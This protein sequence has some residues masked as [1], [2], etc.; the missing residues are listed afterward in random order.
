MTWRMVMGW[1]GKAGLTTGKPT[2][3]FTGGFQADSF[4]FQQL[5]QPHSGNKLGY[6]G[7]AKTGVQ[8]HRVGFSG[9]FVAIGRAVKKLP[10]PGHDDR[11][12]Y[13][14]AHPKALLDTIIKSVGTGQSW[15]EKKNQ[16]HQKGK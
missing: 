2:I 4:L 13:Y 16:S 12:A 10:I 14:L 8:R 7:D 1:S 6:R 3:S 9:I 15:G 11:T 5:H